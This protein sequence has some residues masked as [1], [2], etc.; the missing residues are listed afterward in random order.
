MSIPTD[1]PSQ[2]EMA[3][4]KPYRPKNRPWLPLKFQ[5]QIWQVIPV[6]PRA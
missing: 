1:V 2:A 6:E 3:S 5:T 4:R